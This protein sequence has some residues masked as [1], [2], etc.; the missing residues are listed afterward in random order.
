MPLLRGITH[1]SSTEISME[2]EEDDLEKRQKEVVQ[3]LHEKIKTRFICFSKF[4][5]NGRKTKF[6][7]ASALEKVGAGAWLVALFPKELGYG[8]MI[9]AFVLG[10]ICFVAEFFLVNSEE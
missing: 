7:V 8:T 6:F 10:T 3:D 2:I 5:Y 1:F 9:Y 4:K